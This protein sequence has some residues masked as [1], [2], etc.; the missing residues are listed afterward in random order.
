MKALLGRKVGMTQLFSEEGETTPVTLVQAGPCTVVGF[1]TVDTDGYSA[2]QLGYEAAKHDKKAQEGK[3]KK[4][5]GINPKHVREIKG[6]FEGASIGDQ[7]DV[8]A[9]ETGDD[10]KITGTSKG[11]GFS[12][13][14]KR[15]NFSRGP[16]THGSHNQ[17]RP[18]S[19][20][21]MFPQ[22]V[23]KGKNMAGR[24]GSDTITQKGMQ[25]Q[26]VDPE[27]NVLAIKGALPG[28]KGSL[29]VLKGVE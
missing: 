6:D 10:I 3:Y 22:K 7:V 21:G 27:N 1:K 23:F 19:I 9:F 11:K 26:A 14:I 17:R 2:V 5:A 29:L 24:M 12:G 4:Q 15:H 25:V 13:T 18:G 28:S 20:G 16:M 8:S